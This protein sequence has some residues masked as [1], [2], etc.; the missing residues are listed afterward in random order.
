MN[1]SP[2]TNHVKGPGSKLFLKGPRRNV[3]PPKS[4]NDIFHVMK[5]KNTLKLLRTVRSHPAASQTHLKAKG[6]A[7]Q[8]AIAFALALGWLLISLL[9][10]FSSQSYASCF[11]RNQRSLNNLSKRS[12]LIQTCW[13]DT[14]HRFFS[15]FLKG[16]AVLEVSN[17]KWSS[18]LPVRQESMRSLRKAPLLEQMK[19]ERGPLG[20]PI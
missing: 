4:F 9:E 13:I 1:V 12:K 11:T 7:R 3:W 18:G 17:V 20:T 8:S 10:C 5:L 2:V 16:A 6:M 19:R 15:Q 14:D